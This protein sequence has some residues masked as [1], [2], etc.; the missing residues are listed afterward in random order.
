MRLARVPEIAGDSLAARDRAP[1]PGLRRLPS[2]VT[3]MGTSG[4][5]FGRPG[6][7]IVG[8]A[9]GLRKSGAVSPDFARGASCPGPENLP[10][11]RGGM[12]VMSR[13]GLSIRK[14]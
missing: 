5:L 3:L 8:A 6:R 4:S 7:R 14:E 12:N 2:P 13:A 11:T 1:R 9:E 10:N